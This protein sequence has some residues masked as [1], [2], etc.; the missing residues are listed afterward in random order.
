MCR[1]RSDSIVEDKK[2]GS[3]G[4]L[5]GY[6]LS[7]FKRMI[8]PVNAMRMTLITILQYGAL[9]RQ[10][11]SLETA[12]QLKS[13]V[14]KIIFIRE[15]FAKQMDIFDEALLNA[16]NIHPDAFRACSMFLIKLDQLM[17]KFELRSLQYHFANAIDNKDL[18]KMDSY[19]ESANKMSAEFSEALKDDVKTELEALS[20][21][22]S[23]IP[24][25]KNY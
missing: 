16:D 6:V 17:N 22:D 2:A 9:W 14:T 11:L 4:A 10:T 8:E 15:Q 19:L 20:L 12:K 24:T 25:L 3:T 21:T 7:R 1:V 18:E 23:S 13:T 5:P